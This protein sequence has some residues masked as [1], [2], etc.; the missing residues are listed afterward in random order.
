MPARR[1]ITA[2]VVVAGISTAAAYWLN[3]M[4]R[5]FREAQAATIPFLED[6]CR[7]L[8]GELKSKYQLSLSAESCK[9]KN[10]DAGDNYFYVVI[11][12]DA[13]MQVAMTASSHP[14]Q[15]DIH[16]AMLHIG[17]DQAWHRLK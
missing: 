1:I 7:S 6:Y 10:Y 5:T 11:S 9:A 12:Q 15:N 13:D 4:R 17:R 2:V 16:R 14:T 3:E 8:E